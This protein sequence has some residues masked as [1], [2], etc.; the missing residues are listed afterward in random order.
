MGVGILMVS[1]PEVGGPEAISM[2]YKMSRTAISYA[3]RIAWFD[4]SSGETV[5][6]PDIRLL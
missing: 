5:E 1:N 3:S 2:A 6:L 4:Q